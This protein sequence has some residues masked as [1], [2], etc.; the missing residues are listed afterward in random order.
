MKLKKTLLAGVLAGA[1]AFSSVSVQAAELPGSGSTLGENEEENVKLEEEQET[2]TEAEESEEDWTEPEEDRAEP[3]EDREEQV[4]EPETEAD[5]S[6]LEDEQEADDGEV[7]VQLETQG[8]GAGIFG[9]TKDTFISGELK[10]MSVEKT[11]GVFGERSEDEIESQGASGYG[12]TPQNAVDAGVLSDGSDAYEVSWDKN[13]SDANW[14]TKFTLSARGVVTLTMIKPEDYDGAYGQVTST[15]YNAWNQAVWESGSSLSQN[16][17]A[18]VYDYQIGL[19]AGTYYLNIRSDFYVVYGTVSTYYGLFFDA[20][21]NWEVE[22]NNGS[23]S[24]TPIQIDDWYGGTIGGEYGDVSSDDWFSVHLDEGETYWIYIDNLENLQATTWLGTLYSPRGG[25]RDLSSDFFWQ[26]DRDGDSY[27]EY[28]PESSGTYYIKFWNYH[29]EEIT[30]GLAVSSTYTWS[31]YSDV[32]DDTS[33]RYQA[34]SYVTDRG[35]MNGISGTDRFAPDDPLTRAM[36]ATIIYRMEGSPAASYSPRF[37]DV[38]NGNYYS[39]P[40]L[41]ANAAGIING[42]SN[43][44]LFGSFENITREDMVVIMYRY[45]KYKGIATNGADNLSRFKDAGQVS[46]YARSAVQWAVA[47]GI[48]NGRSNTGLL[49]PKGNASRVETA[50]IIQRFMRYA[51]RD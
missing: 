37:P 21:S 33:W 3:E 15:I 29:E 50:A 11:N 46:A 48:V 34:I 19:D 20:N 17:G 9:V 32:P 14:Y 10:R 22:P 18:D 2:E 4:E 40:V 44:G 51:G 30:Y 47:N 12:R 36:F 41:W 27:Y 28:T 7:T 39:S 26:V 35:I 8:A 38:L 25:S 5:V 45:C 13:T 23:S 49:D 43:T 24:A 42:H 16:D 1:L 31:L 6:G